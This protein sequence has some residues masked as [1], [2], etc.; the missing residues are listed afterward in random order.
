M[1]SPAINTGMPSRQDFEDA[2]YIRFYRHSCWTL[3]VWQWGE[4]ESEP[5]LTDSW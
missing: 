2:I 1:I 5:I 3:R 4:Q